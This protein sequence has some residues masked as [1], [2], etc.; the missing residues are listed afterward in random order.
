[1]VNLHNVL[2]F[3][4]FEDRTKHLQMLSSLPDGEH[5]CLKEAELNEMIKLCIK[6][7]CRKL[8]LKKYFGDTDNNVRKTCDFCLDG[9]C[10]EKTEAHLEV[11]EVLHCLQSMNHLHS[12]V[13]FNLLVLVYSGYKRRQVLSKSFHNIPQY[14]K[15]KTKFSDS[16]F[17]HFVQLLISENIIA[18]K[19]RGSNENGSTPYLIPGN[20]AEALTNGDRSF[21]YAGAKCSRLK[22]N[23]III[24]CV[25][26]TSQI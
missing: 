26:V 1:M 4:R 6:P 17:Q 9:A 10:I 19:L 11:V 7:E 18:E 21:L 5:K 23:N 3:F 25:Y 16:S 14:G 20:R 15:G 2:C 24:I 8:Q 12:K 13:T 22:I